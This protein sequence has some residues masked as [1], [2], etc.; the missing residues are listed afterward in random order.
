MKLVNRTTNYKTSLFIGALLMSGICCSAQGDKESIAIKCE[1][2]A[3][4]LE[5]LVVNKQDEPCAFD[6]KYSGWVIEGTAKLITQGRMDAALYSLK[7]ANGRLERVYLSTN[8]CVYFSPL[9]KDFFDESSS[10]IGELEQP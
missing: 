4:K 6:V 9:V 8:Q 7:I 1:S 3:N 10:L 5:Q 2:L